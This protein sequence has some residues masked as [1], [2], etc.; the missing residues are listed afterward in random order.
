M[1]PGHKLLVGQDLLRRIQLEF[2]PHDFDPLEAVMQRPDNMR[3][4]RSIVADLWR[5]TATK[6]TAVSPDVH[7]V[8]KAFV[9]VLGYTDAVADAHLNREKGLDWEAITAIVEDEVLYQGLLSVWL[10]HHVTR[11]RLL[12]ALQCL[13]GVEWRVSKLNTICSAVH[14]TLAI[15]ALAYIL[16]TAEA[17]GCPT[18]EMLTEW[19]TIEPPATDSVSY[20]GEDRTDKHALLCPIPIFNTVPVPHDSAGNSGTIR[21]VIRWSQER[22]YPTEVDANLIVFDWVGDVRDVI[23][24]FK[25]KAFGQSARMLDM[26]EVLSLVTL[27]DGQRRAAT[28]QPPP[29][30]HAANGAAGGDG[31][32]TVGRGG[33]FSAPGD[34]GILHGSEEFQPLHAAV[35]HEDAQR[36]L[37]S[38]PPQAFSSDEE[39]VDREEAQTRKGTK[40]KNRKVRGGGGG[41]GGGGGDGGNTKG[42]SAAVSSSEATT[43]VPAQD[44]REMNVLGHRDKALSDSETFA[45]LTNTAHSAGI[46]GGTA[47]QGPSPPAAVQPSPLLVPE[48][49]TQSAA[50]FANHPRARYTNNNLET[51]EDNRWAWDEA[52]ESNMPTL[53]PIKPARV[54]NSAG[55]EFSL[56]AA[57]DEIAA[58]GIVLNAPL[59]QETLRTTLQ[60]RVQFF[61]D[62]NVLLSDTSLDLSSVKES[63]CVL[64]FVWRAPIDRDQAERVRDPEDDQTEVDGNVTVT[65]GVESAENGNA[66]AAGVTAV[67]KPRQ[68]Y[69]D[70]GSSDSGRTGDGALAAPADVNEQAPPDIKRQPESSKATAAA[71]AAVRQPH[72]RT[73]SLSSTFTL[74]PPGKES[75]VRASVDDPK[76]DQQPLG[77]AA[78]GV[79]TLEKAAYDLIPPIA[80]DV[81]TI[82]NA[83]NDHTT[84]PLNLASRGSAI[85]VGAV[86][87]A[88]SKGKSP[89]DPQFMRV[90]IEYKNKMQ[91]EANKMSLVEFR[92]KAFAAAA[93]QAAETSPEQ[94]HIG[95]SEGGDEIGYTLFEQLKRNVADTNL[96]A[97]SI[98]YRTA[99]ELRSTCKAVGRQQE[100]L[101]SGKHHFLRATELCREHLASEGFLIPPPN[102]AEH[103]ATIV[104]SKAKATVR[105]NRKNRSI[106]KA[107]ARSKSQKG[108]QSKGH[109]SSI[110]PVDSETG[111]P[112][113]LPAVLT[114]IHRDIIVMETIDCPNNLSEITAIQSLANAGRNPLA[115][116]SSSDEEGDGGGDA[117][118][119]SASGADGESTPE[120]KGN[121]NRLDK[122]EGRKTFNPFQM[123]TGD[124]LPVPESAWDSDLRIGLGWDIHDNQDGRRPKRIDLDCSVVAYAG[125]E[126]FG[127]VDFGN[128]VLKGGGVVHEGD[129]RTGGSK[130]DD[131]TITM[132]LSN[133]DP[134]ITQL[135]LFVTL[136]QGGTF[137][138]LDDI[139]V[140]LLAP[141]D[142]YANQAIQEKEVCRHDS[143]TLQG[144]PESHKTILVAHIK[145]GWQHGWS[146][147]GVHCSSEGSTDKDFHAM[148]VPNLVS[149]GTL[150]W[151]KSKWR[152]LFLETKK[153]KQ[154]KSLRKS[155]RKSSIARGSSGATATPP[156]P[157]PD[158]SNL[159]S[160]ASPNGQPDHGELEV[161]GHADAKAE[162]VA[163]VDAVERRGGAASG[164]AVDSVSYAGSD[165]AVAS[166]NADTEGMEQQGG[167]VQGAGGGQ[168]MK[169]ANAIAKEHSC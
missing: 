130:G 145:S 5:K 86:M 101:N 97:T 75:L 71:A 1:L 136:F 9:L 143:N 49:D 105:R 111:L 128:A 162:T 169:E 26:N 80:G 119:P 134:S 59:K 109:H 168:K 112:L 100:P 48:G 45:Y 31:I 125:R 84:E 66:A 129:C 6:A 20:W 53:K 8:L 37:A 65:A 56:D 89:K 35:E 150:L 36:S 141:V 91:K 140:R 67:Q 157:P 24:D 79:R 99:W 34:Q 38:W 11:A 10:P 160:N 2:N 44:G 7:A 78:T 159:S 47:V 22:A 90:L 121:W 29:A 166:A 135:F 107:K 28:R 137:R 88:A 94:V 118:L 144:V 18:S 41:G 74:G 117:V 142:S 68:P 81:V 42:S 55:F 115:S 102:A 39:G 52:H 16:A 93:K 163:F 161:A 104:K 72:V 139:H 23:Y 96:A 40:R 116:D 108:H 149:T 51:C 151:A 133:L 13:A 146:F 147:H 73:E 60:A 132:N 3:K 167:H 110:I 98:Q 95:Y 33:V 155:S 43:D 50:T 58:Y 64:G 127:Q 154:R 165:S 30:D 27:G 120:N 21:C 126:K 87:E 62:D 148:A 103:A 77:A 82:T 131:E 69:N 25:P 17:V 14:G 4:R 92:N 153:M 19:G 12:P 124:L 57:E 106:K 158:P 63:E 83:V 114:S 152:T 164:G 61:T 70:D 76:V 138:D 85:S 32:S 122:D 156:T 15:K 46:H 54:W 113:G 123:V